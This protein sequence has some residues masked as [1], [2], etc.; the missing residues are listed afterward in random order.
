MPRKSGHLGSVS[1]LMAGLMLV[2]LL[3]AVY[4][5]LQATEESEFTKSALKQSESLRVQQEEE[6][7]R[8]QS[9]EQ[10]AQDNLSKA[11]A[12]TNLAETSKLLAEAL[13]KKAKES[14]KEAEESAKEANAAKNQLMA[15]QVKIV[16]V[17]ANYS[18]LQREIHHALKNEFQKDLHAWKAEL[19]PD[20]TIR[21]NEPE[22]LFALGKADMSAKF[23]QILDNFYP[24]YL[25]VIFKDTYRNHI[26]EIRIEGHT[27]TAWGGAM[28]LQERYLKN[29]ELSQ[30]RALGV[31]DYCFS[32]PDG[33]NYQTL[34]V[35]TLRANGLSFAK[36][37]IHSDGRENQELSR[38]VEFRVLTD[39]Q[40]QL[41]EILKILD[42]QDGH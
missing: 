23:K 19:L 15:L 7:E 31:L 1:D 38:R 18:D 4:Y 26:E 3:I 20:N 32:M 30:K 10:E 36:P 2:F 12:A 42:I 39:S 25:K 14:A 22:V 24:R 41:R 21:F 5:V 37:L 35:K 28:S 13:A 11:E 33:A 8:A 17:V 40:N 9:A 6:K 27:S 16:N 29:A 34:Q